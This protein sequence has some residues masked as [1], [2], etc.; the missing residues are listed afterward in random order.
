VMMKSDE[1][2]AANVAAVHK[3]RKNLKRKAVEYL[4]GKCARCGYDKCIEALDFHHKDPALK[5]HNITG[6]GYRSWERTKIELDKC[7]V[8]CANCHREI[9]AK[10]LPV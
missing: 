2:R 10:I 6:S 9:H 5:D 7:E 4:G 1:Q 8:V 3:C